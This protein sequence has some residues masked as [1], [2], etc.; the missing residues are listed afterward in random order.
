MKVRVWY[1]LKDRKRQ[2]NLT[3]EVDQ[4]YRFTDENNDELDFHVEE[5]LDYKHGIHNIDEWGWE[6]VG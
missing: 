1:Q 2:S 4:S 6:I 5:V 3:L